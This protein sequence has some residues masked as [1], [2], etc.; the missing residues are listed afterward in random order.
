MVNRL[1]GIACSAC[2]TLLHSHAPTLL[3][4]I[5]QPTACQLHAG[6]SR[7]D[8]A[9]IT[10]TEVGALLVD[11]L[12]DGALVECPGEDLSFLRT[13]SFGLLQARRRTGI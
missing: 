7:E 12:G 11:G 1:Q 2:G 3:H 8:L 5:W 10:G 4:A 9:I 13:L 6:T